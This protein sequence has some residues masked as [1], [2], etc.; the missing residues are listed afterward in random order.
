[1]C[2]RAPQGT[3]VLVSFNTLHPLKISA[4]HHRISEPKT[5][6]S[7]SRDIIVLWVAFKVLVPA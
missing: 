7:I 5:S 1:M 3:S 4:R 2:A 6:C